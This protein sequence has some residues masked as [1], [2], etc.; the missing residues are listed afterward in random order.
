MDSD[1]GTTTKKC[2]LDVILKHYWAF[3]SIIGHSEALLG[4][5]KHYWAF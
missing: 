3:L 4:I 1:E 5:L 2:I